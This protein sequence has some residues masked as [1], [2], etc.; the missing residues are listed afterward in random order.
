MKQITARYDS[1]C[2]D[3]SEPIN[4]GERCY[5]A[6]GSGVRCLECWHEHEY[7]MDDAEI[8]RGKAHAQH[9]RDTENFLGHDAMMAEELAWELKDP[10]Y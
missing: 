6:K 10:S 2:K 9:L 4:V 8:A 1:K 3:C 5:W 7:T